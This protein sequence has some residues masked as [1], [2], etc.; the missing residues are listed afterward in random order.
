[1]VLSDLEVRIEGTEINPYLTNELSHH[2]QLDESTF[3]FRGGRS[4]F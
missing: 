4:D 3:I 1:M 2:Y